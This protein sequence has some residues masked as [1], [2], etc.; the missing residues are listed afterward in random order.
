MAKLAI[1][2]VL[3]N[4]CLSFASQ[5]KPTRGAALDQAYSRYCASSVDDE[6]KRWFSLGPDAYSI[7]QFTEFILQHRL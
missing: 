2:L 7:D 5:S 3:E 6:V 1:I 4:A